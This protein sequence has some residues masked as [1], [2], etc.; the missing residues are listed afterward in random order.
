MFELK[1]KFNGIGIERSE[2]KKK[3]IGIN[4]IELIPALA[5]TVV[6][7][8]STI[9]YIIIISSSERIANQ[10]NHRH[11]SLSNIGL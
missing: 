5:T 4:E 7:Y 6:V 3:E 11:T 2:L 8:S 10:A 1:F 9:K